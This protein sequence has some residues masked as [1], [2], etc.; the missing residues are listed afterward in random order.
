MAKYIFVTGGVVS[1]LGKGIVASSIGVLLKA[2]GLKVTMQKF[3]PYINVDPG[4][5]SPL[6]HGEVFVTKDGAETDLDLGHYERFI[7]ENLTR[8]SSVSSGRVYKA[9]ID[10][11]RKGKYAGKTVQ[12]IPH[13]TDEIKRLLKRAA[14]NTKADVVIVEIG[15]TVG[16]MESLPFLEAIR[17]ARRDFGHENTFYIH[18]TLVPYLKAAGELKTK[19]TQHS[20]K[21]LK[22]L[23]IQPDMLVLRSEEPIE[24]EH[25][26]KISL[27]TDLPP[28]SILQSYDMKVVYEILLNLQ[29]QH[30]DDIIL[31]HFEL[32]NL[33]KANVK[34]WQQLVEQIKK[35]DKKLTIAIIGKYVSL[36][37]AY[38]SIIES[39]RH[40]GFKMSTLIDLIWVDSEKVTDLNISKHLE[41]ADGI[42]IPGGFGH[43]GTEGK[44]LALEYG[45][46]NLIPT[47]GIC[48]GMQ[49]AAIEFA[50]NVL[51]I[52]DVCSEEFEN[53]HN[54]IIQKNS[55]HKFKLGEYTTNLKEGSKIREIYNQSQIRERH[56][57]RFE[58]NPEFSDLFEQNGMMITGYNRQIKAVDVLELENHPWYIHVQYHPEYISRPLK[59]HPLFLSFL[60]A[61]K[62]NK[63]LKTD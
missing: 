27:F 10:N 1:S 32:D 34:Q 21:E 24:Q 33:K 46:K 43:R 3:D 62:N 30:I 29:Q 37:D 36:H 52:S 22:S 45:R 12:V 47:L 49:L 2:R 41:G 28:E 14:T 8:Y 42:I 54:P 16:D 50:Q 63:N 58:F 56:R 19:P 5:M 55:N 13:I 31:K 44:L 60:E 51:G 38:I 40:A 59:P 35:S 9:V 18:A 57:H 61:C 26:D 23:G 25:I 17:Q 11:E 48:F 20:V 4:L 7:D 53:C 15:G 6:Q 39:L